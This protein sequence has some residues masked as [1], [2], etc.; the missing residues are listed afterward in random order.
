MITKT[1]SFQR[2]H[3]ARQAVGRGI[4]YRLGHGGTHPQDP[5]PTRT[6]FC[7][8]SGFIAW[9]LGINR[10]PKPER[11]WWLETTNIYRDATS[12]KPFSTFVQLPA[13][14]A[15]CLVVYPDRRVL[16]IRREGHIGLVTR[17]ERGRIITV[18]C[19]ASSGGKTQEAIRE[20]DR[21]ALWT[22]NGAIFVALKQD[23]A[24]ELHPQRSR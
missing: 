15:G 24:R 1:I 4:R 11:P 17:V 9:V 7:D 8:C 16:G 14:E 18:D 23:L 13:P 3:R 5:L 12:G 20:M 21:T 2:I 6:G 10:A 22:S 19:S